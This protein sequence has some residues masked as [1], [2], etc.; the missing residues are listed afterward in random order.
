MGAQYF[1]LVLAPAH[2]DT[3]NPTAG[4]VSLIAFTGPASVVA[5]EWWSD[6]NNANPTVTLIGATVT[7]ASDWTPVERAQLPGG[8]TVYTVT[9]PETMPAMP[10]VSIV[11]AMPRNSFSNVSSVSRWT[12]PLEAGGLGLAAP[13]P[14]TLDDGLFVFGVV[15]GGNADATATAGM[16]FLTYVTHS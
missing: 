2:S 8:V 15:P 16:T 7:P 5:L 14:Q 9:D 3:S 10:A 1:T 11:D 4:F 6:S 12:L 13:F